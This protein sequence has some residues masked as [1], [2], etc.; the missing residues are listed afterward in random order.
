MAKTTPKKRK[1]KWLLISQ[2]IT[3]F[4][5]G[6]VF[7][8]FIIFIKEIGA[9]FTQFGIAYALF[10]LSAAL[11]HKI[12][13]GWSDKWGRK[14]FLLINSW[15]TALLFLIFPIVTNIMQVYVLQIFLGMFGAMHKTSEKALVADFTDGKER[16]KSIGA[17]HGWIA[18]CSALAIIAGGYL[19]DL[20]TLS[21]IF[22]IGSVILFVSG[23]SIIKINENGG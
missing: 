1:M 22:Y 15:G 21:I 9:N 16:G 7:P 3:L 4:G 11:V 8:F 2:S 23:V 20:L 17:Y 18:I 19:I 6:F 13:G 10:A 14:V 12:I 5:G